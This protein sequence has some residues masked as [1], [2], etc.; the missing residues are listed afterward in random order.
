MDTGRVLAMVLLAAINTVGAAAFGEEPP[1]VEEKPAAEVKSA[2]DVKPEKKWKDEGELSYVKTSGNSKTTNLAAK[3]Q[4]KYQFTEKVLG[5]WKV[6]AILGENE[7]VKSAENYFTD[8]KAD[9]SFTERFYS[10]AN[11]GWLKNK[12]AG[13]DR[14]LYGGAGAGYKFLIGPVNFLVGELG[15]NY[16]SNKYIDETRKNYLAGR[17]FGKYTYAF[18][19]KN[20]FSQTVEYLYDFDDSEKYEVNSETALISALTGYLSMKA[21]YVV[22]YKHKPIPSTLKN[23]DT[24]TTVALVVSF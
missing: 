3:N 11:A 24:T 5:T 19:E 17:A 10:L 20:N 1:V 8:L 16:V 9:Y 21:A 7:G 18:T 2:G 13:I 12:F 23:S 15:L 6:G 14:R 22:N 4:V